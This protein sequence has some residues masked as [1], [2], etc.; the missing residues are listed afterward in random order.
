MSNWIATDY[1]ILNLDRFI[2]IENYR[3][4]N[5]EEVVEFIIRGYDE[6]SEEYRL[7]T[8]KDETE[9]DKVFK[10]IAFHMKPKCL[11]E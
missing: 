3:Y 6:N 10:N 2:Y 9:T 8:S 4:V 1:V 7:F 11:Y 5:K